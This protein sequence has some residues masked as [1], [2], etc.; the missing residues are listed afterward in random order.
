VVEPLIRT[1][2]LRRDYRSS[3]VAVSALRGASLAVARGEFVAIMG[4]SGSGKST[5]MNILGLLDRPTSGT[6][7]LEG[8]D[9]G[10]LSS[11]ARAGL[12]SEKIG[13]VFQSYNLLNRSTALENVALP[14]VYA[15]CPRRERH[16]RAEDAL[17]FVGL[18]DRLQHL[19]SQL[20][21][22]EQQRV[23][24]ARALVNA[25]SLILA[26]EPTGALD[27][28]T[29][30][31]ILDLLQ[32]MNCSGRTIVLVTHEAEVA[33]NARRIVRMQD[34]RIVGDAPAGLAAG[35]PA[36]RPSGFGSDRLAFHARW[37]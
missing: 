13:F 33:R 18:A 24:I 32:S 16:R 23:A 30:R 25:P 12:R 27:S 20:S 29:G 3:G 8:E 21:G 9:A 26:D 6:Y 4:P 19:P 7:L 34:G 17:A 37:K 5:L 1:I 35:G 10:T 11:D 31:E 36:D 28:G 22:G 14:L 2:D 15:R